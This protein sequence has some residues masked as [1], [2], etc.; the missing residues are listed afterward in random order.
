[1]I[2]LS[3]RSAS[4]F[5]KLVL[6]VICNCIGAALA[7]VSHVFHESYWENH[8]VFFTFGLVFYPRLTLL[9]LSD[10][11]FDATLLSWLFWLISPRAYKMVICPSFELINSFPDAL[12]AFYAFYY[13]WPANPVSGFIAVI[14]AVIA[15]LL[16]KR[17]LLYGKDG[18]S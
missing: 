5:Y 2:A 4:Y 16:E 3:S 12:V 7:R 18:I 14:V 6:F 8:G 9:L 1:M 15:E 11:F 17:I 13:Y 10:F